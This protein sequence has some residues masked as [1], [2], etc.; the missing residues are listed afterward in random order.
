MVSVPRSLTLSAI[1]SARPHRRRALAAGPPAAAAVPGWAAVLPP[2]AGRGCCCGPPQ[3]SACRRAAT[4][5]LRPV[6]PAAPAPSG[7][8]APLPSRLLPPAGWGQRGRLKAQPAA[9]RTQT[10]WARRRELH[11]GGSDGARPRVSTL[12]RTNRVGFLLCEHLLQHTPHKS[13]RTH[14]EAGSTCLEVPPSL[15]PPNRH[16]PVFFRWVS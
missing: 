11:A 6:P 3:T 15:V 14:T 9:L 2:A 4:V 1:W 16:P 5:S 12:A 13:R 7:N 10:G 8:Q